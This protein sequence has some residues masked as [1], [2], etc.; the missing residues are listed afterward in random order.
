M[1]S[2]DRAHAEDIISTINTSASAYE[3]N[4]WEMNFV[5]DME[6][7][8]KNRFFYPTEKQIACLESIVEKQDN[9]EEELWGYDDH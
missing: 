9:F 5:I 8:L 6:E 3:L 4:D 2:D 1:P 7:K